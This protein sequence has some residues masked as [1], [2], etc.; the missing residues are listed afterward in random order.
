VTAVIRYPASGTRRSTGTT[1]MD[2]SS[3]GAASARFGS[4]VT[5]TPLN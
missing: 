3:E 5:M 2:Y 4:S 1:I